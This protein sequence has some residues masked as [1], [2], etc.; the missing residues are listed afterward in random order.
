MAYKYFRTVQKSMWKPQTEVTF[1]SKKMRKLRSVFSSEQLL[2]NLSNS[3]FSHVH[4]ADKTNCGDWWSLPANYFT[5]PCHDNVFD[6]SD[7]GPE[8]EISGNVIVGGGGLIG[9]G[10]Y[11][12][13]KILRNSRASVIGWGIGNN[14]IDDKLSDFVSTFPDFPSYISMFKL[15]GVRDDVEGLRWVPCVS[16]MHP[17]FSKKYNVNHDV[18]VFEHK[19]ISI[20]IGAF[21][22]MTNEGSD[23]DSIISFLASGDTVI[24]NSYHGAYWA[25]L[26][27]KKCVA[28]PFSS[29]FN[30]MRHSPVLSKINDW[31]ESMRI[32]RIYPDALSECRKANVD[33][34]KSVVDVVF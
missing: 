15:L 10:F 23:I 7:L 16:C 28:I 30:R 25:T 27:G 11:Q 32:S 9:P 12:L 24:T 8:V 2:D 22:T 4:R 34:Y 1:N 21:P 26:L 31:K 17:A 19:R 29:K 33:F 13:E 6:I 5:F 14:M 18:V 20:N 3:N